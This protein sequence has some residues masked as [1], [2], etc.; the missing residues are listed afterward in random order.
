MTTTPVRDIY[1]HES[2]L[3]LQEVYGTDW[4]R[5]VQTTALLVFTPDAVV[6]GQVAAGVRLLDA[7]GFQ[8]IAADLVRI[9]RLRCREIWRRE[10]GLMEPETLDRL[11]VCDLLFP[12]TDSIAVLLRDE[13]PVAD[14][15]ASRRLSRLKGSGE[16][17]LRE[18]GT[19]RRALYSPNNVYRLVHASDGPDELVRELG[20]LFGRGR[21]LDLLRSARRGRVAAD[22]IPQ[23]V[24]RAIEPVGA[25]ELDTTTS[26]RRVVA[27]VQARL[28]DDVAL[29]DLHDRLAKLETGAG[30]GFRELRDALDAAAVPVDTWDL[31]AIGAVALARPAAPTGEPS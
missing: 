16:P 22:A 3:D 1:F 9:D 7:A 26:M 23:L 28:R 31:V 4:M 18:P 10:L 5:W 11:A 13:R 19:L 2:L 8:P 27:A 30:P 14:L 6:S 21:R 29:Q 24:A 12:Y 20:I 25:R 17:S 15:P